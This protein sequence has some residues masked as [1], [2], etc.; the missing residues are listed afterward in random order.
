MISP[1][2][3]FR[4]ALDVEWVNWTKSAKSMKLTLTNG[5]STNIN[6]VLGQGGVGQA[7]LVVDFPLN[8]GDAVLVKIGGEY[9]FSKTF[10][11]RLGYAYGN[12]PIPNTT[13]NPV[14][15]ANLVHHITA[16]STF[17][18]TKRALLNL[19]LEYGVKNSQVSDTPNLVASEYNGSTTTMQNLL[20][21]I[22]V[23]YFLNR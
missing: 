17:N 5:Q 16:G 11:L 6:K 20:G 7:P 23:T 3:N 22:S 12:N 18:I 10:T 2:D 13:I 1:K 19:G 9:D 8:W 15:P 4:I 21:H 14:V